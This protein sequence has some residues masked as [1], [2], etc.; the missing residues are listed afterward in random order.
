V[1]RIVKA[2]ERYNKK[3]GADR[4]MVIQLTDTGAEAPA[5]DTASES[6]ADFTAI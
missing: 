2:Y 6:N 3:I 5:A 1:Q 4:Q